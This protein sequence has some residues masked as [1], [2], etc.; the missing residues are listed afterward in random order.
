[1]SYLLAVSRCRL[2]PHR[3]WSDLLKRP[4]VGLLRLFFQMEPTSI[5]T[6]NKTKGPA[7]TKICSGWQQPIRVARC[8]ATLLHV[9]RFQ[10]RALISVEASHVS[11][12]VITSCSHQSQY[13]PQG[14]ALATM[15]ADHVGQLPGQKGRRIEHWG[16]KGGG[17]SCTTCS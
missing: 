13:L 5:A 17:G 1:M 12:Y 16:P 6:R 2:H 15:A 3:R 11:I 7:S 9:S 8:G 4:L 10:T 14:A